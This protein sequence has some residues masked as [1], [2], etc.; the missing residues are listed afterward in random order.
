MAAIRAYWRAIVWALIVVVCAAF[1]VGFGVAIA[2]AAG[3][4]EPLV[5]SSLTI[6]EEADRTA[7]WLATTLRAEVNPRPIEVT[8]DLYSHEHD[9]EY[10]VQTDSVKLRPRIADELAYRAGWHYRGRY[11]AAGPHLLIHELLHRGSTVACWGVQPSGVNVEEGIVD[12][13]TAD[14]LPAWGRRFWQAPLFGI[15]RYE[16]DVAA[17]RAASARATG[18]RSWR[19]WST[20]SWRYRLWGASCE[21][22]EAMLAEAVR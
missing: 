3:P 16:A 22:R 8:D 5:V 21:G 19:A 2:N 20:R 18:S 11:Y 10:Y 17:I 4:D 6:Q 12:A 7:A 1:W 14:L 15:P 13:V 9:G